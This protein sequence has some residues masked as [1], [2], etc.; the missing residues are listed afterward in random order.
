MQLANQ[1]GAAVKPIKPGTHIQQEVLLQATQTRLVSEINFQ[2]WGEE[3][4]HSLCR[5]R[6][7]PC[8]HCLLLLEPPILLFDAVPTISRR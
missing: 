3:L 1:V 2:G 7:P 8:T 4:D 5:P 6:C